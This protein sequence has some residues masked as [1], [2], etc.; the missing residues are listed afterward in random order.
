[1]KKKQFALTA[2]QIVP[3]ATG[4]GGCIATD[5][6]TVHGKKVGY[7]VR[8]PT[9][10]PQDSGWCFMSGDESQDYM[11]NP[12]NHGI[13]DVNTIANYSPDIVPFIDAPPRTAFIHQGGS[14]RKA[15]RD[16]V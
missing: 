16:P 11:D 9:S 6:I 13:Y 5:M 2:S 14:H 3:L 1:M 12:D 7:M 15:C 10:R 4:R 8:E